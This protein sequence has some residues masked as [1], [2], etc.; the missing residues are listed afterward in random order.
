[1]R[2]VKAY[3]PGASHCMDN[4][5]MIAYVGGHRAQ[6]GERLESG[7]GALSRWPVEQM[8]A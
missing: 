7:S 6:R 1:M 5:A 3:F 4:A 2:G 8:G